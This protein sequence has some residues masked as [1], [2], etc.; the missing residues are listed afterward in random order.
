[1]V[2]FKVRAGILGQT[3][4]VGFER[5]LSDLAEVSKSSG[6]EVG[7]RLPRIAGPRAASAGSGGC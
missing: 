3:A 4:V 1:M 2:R 5:A 6:A 7:S